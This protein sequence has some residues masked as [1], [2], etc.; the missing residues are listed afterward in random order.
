LLV[1][2]K[3]Y[4]LKAPDK[5]DASVAEALA[6]YSKG[7]TGTYVRGLTDEA[8]RVAERIGRV[9]VDVGGTACKVPAAAAYIEK[10]RQRGTIGKK[11]K[12][13]KC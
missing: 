13:V 6:K 9:A 5:A 12:T 11:R 3:R 10:V 4:E 7:D 8:L 2:G 1:D